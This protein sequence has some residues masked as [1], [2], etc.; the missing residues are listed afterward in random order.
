[1]KYKFGQHT[2]QKKKKCSNAG[3]SFCVGNGK[4]AF[5]SGARATYLINQI[6]KVKQLPSKTPRFLETQI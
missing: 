1:M 6:N 3:N 4:Y 5:H 2:N